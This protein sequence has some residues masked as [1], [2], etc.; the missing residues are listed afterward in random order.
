MIHIFG[1]GAG[2]LK[3]LSGDAAEALATC[4]T[5]FGG[6]RHLDLLPF[7]VAKHPWPKPWRLPIK[8]IETAAKQGPVGILVSGDPSWFSAA[9]GLA[10]NLCRVGLVA[11]HGRCFSS[12][13]SQ[14]KR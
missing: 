10:V 9:K 11:V 4:Q 14:N 13:P 8:E 12:S 7:E 5:L 1:L 2:G 3:S 6:T